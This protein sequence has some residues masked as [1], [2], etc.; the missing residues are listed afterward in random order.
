[1]KKKGFIEQH[2]YLS[3]KDVGLFFLGIGLTMFILNVTA[4]VQ[5]YPL[6]GDLKEVYGIAPITA[7]YISFASSIILIAYSAYNIAQ[8]ED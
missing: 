6:I 7:Y 5:L 8:C 2:F 4:M 3:H 1:M